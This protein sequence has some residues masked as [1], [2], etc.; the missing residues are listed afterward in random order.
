MHKEEILLVYDKECP[1]CD[2]YCRSVHIRKD[3]GE[4]KIVKP[5]HG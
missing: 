3:A 2:T 4:L 5:D 1:V